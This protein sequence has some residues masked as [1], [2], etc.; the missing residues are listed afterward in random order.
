MTRFSTY[1]GMAGLAIASMQGPSAAQVPVL[2]TVKPVVPCADLT[3]APLGEGDL[4]DVRLTAAATIGT[5]QGAFCKISGTI[6]PATIGFEV[7]LPV[8]R[9]TQRFVQSAQNRLPIAQAGTNPPALRG[10]LALAITDKG[11]PGIS[12]DSLWTHDNA[13]KRIDWAY[14]ANHM[15]ALAAKALI[16]AYYGQPQRY[17]YFV[18]CSMGGR[19]ALSEAQHFPADFDGVI[20][21]AP[22]VIDSV[23]NAF[24]PGWEWA[25]NRRADGSII[26]NQSHLPILHTA[27]IRHCAARSG[28][29]DGML[30]HP[31]A[32]VF[33]PEWVTCKPGKKP[34][35]QCLTPEQAGV[36]KK[37]YTGP[38]D[39]QGRLLDAG[40]LPLGS[41]LSWKL[42]TAAG[43]ANPATDPGNA[44]V[45]LLAPT[46]PAQ[47]AAAMRRD[48]A[49]SKAWFDRA[50]AMA[51][52]WNTANTNL[53]PFQQ[54]GGKLILW[55][56]ASDPTVQPTSTIA[57]YEGVRQTLGTKTTD[58][59]ARFFLA[60]GVNHCGGGEG[61]DQF[62]L[63]SALMSWT[64][65]GQAPDR[66]V[67]GKVTRRAVVESNP[68]SVPDTPA[69][70]TRPL[71][72]YPL[73]AAHGGKG[74]PRDAAS[75]RPAP[76]SHA[77]WHPLPPE[78]AQFFG[79]D[80]QHF[81][82]VRNGRLEADLP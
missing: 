54:Q 62:D 72:P 1:A 75:Y 52:L 67:A 14:R 78:I 53:R 24:Y 47:D 32:C 57:Y 4:A 8:E 73:V 18:G 11:G 12:R 2:P 34:D 82:S 76:P 55:I 70:Y 65:A 50:A 9:W 5:A 46:D 74:D 25:A 66:L 45:R 42:S 20:A 10:E 51:P 13:Q 31:A 68:F 79:P 77:A 3:R 44:L 36:A 41:E 22:V 48:F 26:L 64:E 37:L 60:P 69:D 81:Y 40:G 6:G 35:A 38:T 7:Y 56:G 61:P 15:T 49:Y 30:Q 39:A 17:A 43:P 80:N 28:L 16:R 59:F 27:A 33:D 63:L 58:A 71:F 29:I 23:H 21:G 19:E